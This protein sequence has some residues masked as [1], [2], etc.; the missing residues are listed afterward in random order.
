[1]L[2]NKDLYGIHKLKRAF[3]SVQKSLTELDT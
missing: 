1:M 2:Q 3:E